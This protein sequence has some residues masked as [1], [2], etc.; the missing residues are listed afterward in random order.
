[1]K[2]DFGKFY[3]TALALLM[4]SVALNINHNPIQETVL[5]LA[6]VAS[7]IYIYIG[8]KEIW[9]SGIPQ[10]EKILWTVGFLFANGIAGA[11]YL[12]SGR[13]KILN[14]PRNDQ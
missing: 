3:I 14:T 11:I 6:L 13:K 8:I 12:I 2:S 7:L 1:M 5:T 4:I 10:N 9:K